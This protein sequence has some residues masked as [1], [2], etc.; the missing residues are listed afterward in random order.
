MKNVLLL[1]ILALLVS[2]VNDTMQWP[3]SYTYG[4]KTIV[5]KKYVYVLNAVDN[6]ISTFEVIGLEKHFRG[7]TTIAGQARTMI[8]SKDGRFMFV[9][10]GAEDEVHVY[11]INFVN[12]SLSLIH[13]IPAGDFPNGLELSDDGDYL[14][15]G[16]STDGT[17]TSFLVNKATGDLTQIGVYASGA[18]LQD[19]KQSNGNLYAA[20]YADGTITAYAINGDG[21]LSLIEVQAVG[22]NPFRIAVT[23]EFVYVPNK[24]NDSVSVLAIAGDGSLDLVETKAVGDNPSDALVVGDYAYVSNRDSGSIHVYAIAADGSL[25]LEQDVTSVCAQPFSL[26]SAYGILSVTCEGDAA[27]QNFLI[28]VNGNLTFESSA[29]VGNSPYDI[30]YISVYY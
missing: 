5:N 4:G 28:G 27:V 1:A 29:S 16:N 22:T 12:G 24:A 25:T 20:S 7:T 13:Q 11:G 17:I 19:L 26:E 2:C 6:S 8:P 21:S 23:D 9:G 3:D 15:V 14:F 30:E 18:N 10:S